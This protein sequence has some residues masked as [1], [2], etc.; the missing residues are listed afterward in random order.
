MSITGFSVFHQTRPRN[1]CFSNNYK[2][3]LLLVFDFNMDIQSVISYYQAVSYILS[4]L[5]KS[6]FKSSDII[7][8]TVSE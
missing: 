3:V 5:S 7:K 1:S 8:K 4:S 6:Q 2:P